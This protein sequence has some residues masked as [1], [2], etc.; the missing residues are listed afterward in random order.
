MDLI[1]RQAAIDTVKKHYRVDN[2]LLEVIVFELENLPSAEPERLTD[3]SFEESCTDCPAY[4][5]ENH[6]CP[7]FNQ[8]IRMALKDANLE[9]CE[10][11]ISR[12]DAITEFSCCELTPD[13]GIDANYAIDFLKQ[14]P[15][16]QPEKRTEERMEER[17][18]T[19]ACDL[20]DRQAAIDAL[21]DMHCKSDEDGYVWI[22]RSDAWARI[23]ALPSAQP[24]KRMEERAETHAC[25]LIDREAAIEALLE[26]GQ[27]SKRYRLGE[28]WE[29]NFDEIREAMATVPSAQPELRR[30]EES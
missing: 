30:G 9:A 26:K 5:T 14:L 7:R 29:L 22:I 11:C 12:Q 4:D 17:M 19:H 13:G 23:D 8:V 24:E 2:D 15:S 25:D 3:Y 21:A 18:E 27:R 20:I 16:A 1:D 10:D 6:R 28:I